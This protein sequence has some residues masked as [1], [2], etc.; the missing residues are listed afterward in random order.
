MALAESF[1]RSGK[2]TLLVDANLR[3]PATTEWLDVVPSHAAPF[4]VHLANPE[5]RYLPVSVAVAG[6]RTF[7]F[8]PSFTSARFPVDLLNQGL[9][10]QLEAWKH[11]YDVIILDATPVLPFADT[12]AIAAYAT[13][14]AMCAS[15]RTTTREQLREACDSLDRGDARVLG[16]IITELS[17]RRARLRARRGDMTAMERQAV[18]PYRTSVPSTRKPIEMVSD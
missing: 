9:P 3:H 1:S 11:G 12:L 7:D 4:E 5:Q 15:S 6:R 18:D 17:P 14:V 2:Q 13:G 16:V 10:D 8:I